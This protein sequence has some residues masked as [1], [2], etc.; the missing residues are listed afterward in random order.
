M[1]FLILGF[2]SL[3]DENFNIPGNAGLKDQTFAL[4]WINKN[5]ENF[6]GDPKNITIFG[7]SA[8]GC[9]VHYHTIS[10]HS[11]GLFKRAIPMSGNCLVKSWSTVPNLNWAQ[12]LAVK[13]GWDERGGDEKVLEILENF[14]PFDIVKAHL[15]ISKENVS[16]FEFRTF[17]YSTF[18][19]R[20]PKR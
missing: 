6:G 5:I 19:S 10:N 3:N 8:G 18:F 2:L 12:K 9:S 14:D 17:S 4:K 11:K 15:K 1:N 7:E 16:D 13:L 20:T